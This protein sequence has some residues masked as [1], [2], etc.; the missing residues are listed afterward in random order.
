MLPYSLDSSV[1]IGNRF[2]K[3][4]VMSAI[5]FV[6]VTACMQLALVFPILLSTAVC[7]TVV[8]LNSVVG[9][10]SQVFWF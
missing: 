6:G 5:L 1:R 9:V 8:I 2:K 7:R 3:L 4:Q 10:G